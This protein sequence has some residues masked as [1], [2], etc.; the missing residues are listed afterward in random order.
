MTQGYGPQDPNQ[1]GYGQQPPQ[2]PYGGQPPYGTPAPQAGYG[3]PA[4]P[5]PGGYVPDQPGYYM[6][7][8]LANWPQRVGAYL[9]DY[10]IA[11]IP[12]FLAVLLFSGTD[13]GETP[14]AGAGVVAFLLYLVSL[15]IWIYNRAIQ[16]GR[17]GQ[18]WGK[19]VL[20]LRLVRMA[21]GQPMGAGMCFLRDLL[22]IL[23]ALICY[24]GYLWPIWDARRQCLFSD[25][26]MN[27]VVLSEG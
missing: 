26:I 4:A 6:G 16:M 7:R 18:S 22:H 5:A 1:P 19:Q 21:D 17:T 27:T 14:S 12:A 2:P 11:A 23:D 9:I 24:I 15:G 10:L 8:T 20:N 13:P 25:K 3:Q